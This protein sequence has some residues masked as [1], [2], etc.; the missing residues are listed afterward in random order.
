[1]DERRVKLICLRDSSASEVN[2]SCDNAKPASVG[3]VAGEFTRLYF[4]RRAIRA[5]RVQKLPKFEFSGNARVGVRREGRSQTLRDFRGSHD[6]EQERPNV[7][8]TVDRRGQER[9]V[10][11]ITRKTRLQR[12]LSRRA[13]SRGSEPAIDRHPD[14]WP[15]HSRKSVTSV[16][17]RLTSA[18]V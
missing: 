5:W 9:A 4:R 8:A 2:T 18:T 17:R 13:W 16:R 11:L 7:A 14:G 12:A 1:M 15:S 6:G 3:R 10:T